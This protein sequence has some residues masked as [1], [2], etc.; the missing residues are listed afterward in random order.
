MIKQRVPKLFNAVFLFLKYSNLYIDDIFSL[1]I[2]QLPRQH[3]GVN[4]HSRAQE[5][6]LVLQ[7]FVALCNYYS[8]LITNSK[9]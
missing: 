5:F 6:L 3:E 1:K 9:Y 7:G 4:Y 2:P 8:I